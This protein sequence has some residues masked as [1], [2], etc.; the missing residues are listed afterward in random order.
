M[1]RPKRSNIAMET[2][3][4]VGSAKR[5]VAAP[6]LGW[7]PASANASDAGTSSSPT[8]SGAHTAATQRQYCGRLGKVANCIVTVHLAYATADLSFQALLDGEVYLPK[9]WADD[10]PRRQ[11]AG[12][13]P[14]A[15]YRAKWAIAL[16]QL[17]RAKA[18]GVPLRWVLADADYG[19]KPG[20]RD[21]VA[22]RG[23]WYL[24][25]AR[26]DLVLRKST[27]S[28]WEELVGRS[29]RKANAI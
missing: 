5:N 4:A 27:D 10:Q 2:F 17:D 1:R 3:V 18:N 8:A 14:G 28:L 23:L 6:R 20:F 7:A 25:D 12:I 29:E 26:A 13:P 22:A 21:G 19:S 11:A 24:V 16:A 15:A 9:D